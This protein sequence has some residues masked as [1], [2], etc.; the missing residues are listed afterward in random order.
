MRINLLK[1]EISLIT[2][3]CFIFS[4]QTHA[5]NISFTH[6]AWTI[7]YLETEHGFKIEKTVSGMQHCVLNHS[8]PE[9]SYELNG[10]STKT[11]TAASFGSLNYEQSTK[12]NEFG[13]PTCYTFTFSAPSNGDAVRMV[14][15]FY[16]TDSDYLITS[17]QVE[18][19]NGLNL[20]TNYI[21]PVCV[22]TAYTLFSNNSNNRMLK[23]PYDN[24]GFGR[25]HKYKMTRS[26]T[27]YEV[28]AFFEGESRRGLVI[29]SVDHDCWK[30]ALTATTTNNG[31]ISNLKVYSGASFP[32]SGSDK[33][34][35]TGTRDV[36]PHGKLSG[37]S[38]S[39]ARM[40]IGFFDDWREGMERFGQA[41]TIVVPKH[42]SWL[43]GTPMGWQSWGVLQDANSYAADQAIAEYYNNTL[44]NLGFYNEQGKQVISIDSWDN[45]SG[46]EQSQLA[47][48]CNS[49]NQ[50]PGL[51]KTPFVTWWGSVDELKTYNMNGSNYKCYD[52]CL[53]VNGAPYSPN[54]QG[55]ALDPT[56]PGTQAYIRS[57]MAD[58]RNKGYKYVKVDFTSHGM[59]QAD[60]YYDPNITTGVQAYNVGMKIFCEEANRAGMFVALSIAPLFPYQYG[61]SRRI[62][63]DT[64]GDI[65]NTEYSMNALSGG[66]WTDEMYQYNDPD[67]LVFI[68]HNYNKWI[69]K[70]YSEGENRARMTNGVV[71]GMVLVSD[72]YSGS[73]VRDQNGG[74]IESRNRAQWLLGNNDINEV[75]RLG[76]SFRPVYGYKEYNGNDYDAENFFY[77]HTDKYL[78]VAVINYKTSG[79]ISGNLPL[80]LMGLDASNAGETKELWNNTTV[81]LSS[82]NLPYSVAKKDARI[83]RIAKKDYSTPINKSLTFNY[84]ETESFNMFRTSHRTVPLFGDFDNDGV[85]DMYYAG[86]SYNYGWAGQTVIWH[87]PNG[88]RTNTSG[89]PK[90]AFAQGSKAFDFNMDGL[91]DMLIINS[92]GNDTG[93]DKGYILAINKGNSQFEIL[94][95]AALKNIAPTNNGDNNFNEG[96]PLKSIA[97]ADYDKDGYPDLL[98]QGTNASGRFTRLLRN[99]SGQRY[100]IQNV[101]I[102]QASH[103]SVL[104]GDFN[105]DGW[106][107]IV[108]AGYANAESVYGFQGG[109]GLFFYRN[110]RNGNFELVT[111]GMGDVNEIC[112]KWGF[113]NDATLNVLDFDQDGKQDLIL[114]GGVGPDGSSIGAKGAKRSVL[115]KNL[116]NDGHTFAFRELPANLMPV[117]GATERVSAMADFNG[118][119]YPDYI[120]K[121]WNETWVWGFSESDGKGGYNIHMNNPGILD[122]EN[123]TAFGDVDNDGLLDFIT[124]GWTANCDQLIFSR[125]TTQNVLVEKPGMPTGL[126][127]NYNHEKQQL[128][129]SWEGS[130]TASGSRSIYNLYLKDL[131]TGKMIRMLVPAH[132]ASG[133][134]KTY[135]DFSTYVT[136]TSYTFENIGCGAYAVGVQAVAYSWQASA[137]T[138]EN[139]VILDESSTTGTGLNANVEN[140]TV[141][142]KR[143]LK[144]NGLWNTFCVPFDMSLEQCAANSITDVKE[145]SNVSGNADD[146]FLH[147]AD[148]TS[149][150]SGKTYLICSDESTGIITVN[151]VTVKSAAPTPETINE[152]T[153][154]GNYENKVIRNGE[155]FINNN[156]FYMADR[157]V[158]VKGYRGTITV[159]DAAGINCLLIDFEDV[160]D[161]NAINTDNEYK[162]VEVYTVSGIKLRSGSSLEKALK[163]LPRG[164]Y[165]VNGEKVVK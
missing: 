6:G 108:V 21:A 119:G 45:M 92:G 101:P 58:L 20:K 103:G 127:M 143:K 137:F 126:S 41:N 106:P 8:V 24:D 26:M 44:R 37:T 110:L 53:K 109:N 91:T 100:E 117:S 19:E 97:V 67:H 5:E 11:V 60:S 13:E 135:A 158:T 129:V 43:H 156:A 133:R 47:N 147:F 7:T 140:A 112:T 151:G 165:I 55:Y 81:S 153:L 57:E 88:A 72:N 159:N 32:E 1:N 144:E 22:N 123:Q 49:N 98:L 39:S 78:Y 111:D 38:V 130:T 131:K 121:G 14:Q 33:N 29:G 34:K 83:Y 75:A 152:V 25:Y 160:T 107:D 23:V 150:Q 114:V 15:T 31:T 102:I 3:G 93:T 4:L 2:L 46:D 86:T 73:D 61:N 84:N 69:N 146:K 149:I 52:C 134:Q 157:E 71:T 124:S 142:L 141:F 54:G 115:L 161:I 48:Y 87:G 51:Y 12:M 85:M 105:N 63:C 148:A 79:T 138:T 145:L 50:I 59:I 162:T 155:F 82:G 163:G 16:V 10:G 74:A 36:L 77:H 64:W 42:D 17:L 139:V 62:A 66:W 76:K 68:A 90:S 70:V 116:S 80:S 136:N 56:H 9:L 128:T 96:T 164:V 28:G 94:E 95:D 120:C 40:F 125:N 154:T 113:S 104:F 99:I 132:E 35:D 118:D 18:S 89:I 30:N 27:S 122:T 65:S